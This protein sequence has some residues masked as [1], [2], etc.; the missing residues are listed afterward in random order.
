MGCSNQKATEVDEVKKDE[1][2]E[3]E[4][5]IEKNQENVEEFVLEK[6]N[7]D[8]AGNQEEQDKPQEEKDNNEIGIEEEEKKSE[9]EK[10]SEEIP[11]DI[12]INE[13]EELNIDYNN[14]NTMEKNSAELQ[15]S[16]NNLNSKKNQKSKKKNNKKK[17]PFIITQIQSNPYQKIKIVI[18]AC[19]FCDEYMM[20][21]WCNKD[22]YIKFKVEGK[23]RIDKNYDYTDSKGIPSN[24]S[25]G[26]NYGALIGRIGLGKKFVVA[27]ETAILVKENGPLFLRQNLPKKLKIEPEGKLVISIYDGVYKKI[28]EINELIG[29]KESRKIENKNNDQ[30]NEKNSDIKSEKVIVNNTRIER[31]QKELEGNLR[32]H[33]NN[34]RMNTTLFYEKYITFNNNLFMTKQYLEKIEKGNKEEKGEKKE[35]E[36]NQQKEQKEKIDKKPLEENDSCY[37][38]LDNYFTFPNQ[39]QFR[40]N[41]NKNNLRNNLL[42]LDEDISYFLSDQLC[43]TVKAKVKITQ[44]DNPIEIIIQY[45]LDK[46]FRTYIFDSHSQSLIIKIIKNYFSNC[47]LVVIAIALDGDYT[48]EEEK[49]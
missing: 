8:N 28:E 46:K 22:V 13:N 44:K 14:S 49:I 38:Y 16:S 35:E 5:I 31:E 26:F 17:K 1:K 32:I 42:Q 6:N 20:P 36:K 4:V 7:E 23:W 19:S 33:L 9:E 30:N 47:T 43:T 24:H 27:D 48:K 11:E 40:K 39:I 3:E 12:N 34:L 2:N 25:S 10:Q 15:G 21:I 29:W 41:L 45:L 37:E 18:N